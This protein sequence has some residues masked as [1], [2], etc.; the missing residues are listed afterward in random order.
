MESGPGW[1]RAA[2]KLRD[3]SRRRNASSAA[4]ATPT[5]MQARSTTPCWHG[6][7]YVIMATKTGPHAVSTILPIA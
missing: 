2:D 1:K 4:F 3:N 5:K 6:T 7:S